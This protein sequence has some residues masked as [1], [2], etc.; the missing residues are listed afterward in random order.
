MSAKTLSVL[1]VEDNADARE[2]LRD[3]LEMWGH[4]VEEAADGPAGVAAMIRRPFDVALIDLGL[5][6]LDGY[7]VATRIRT[8]RGAAPLLIALTGHSGSDSAQKTRQAGFD[9]HVVKP[10][11]PEQLS[12]LLEKRRTT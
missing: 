3:L 5:P 1:L 6:G 11:E 10:V 8:S 4:E 2:A 12:A 7:E 9:L